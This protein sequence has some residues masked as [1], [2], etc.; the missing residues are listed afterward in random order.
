MRRDDP[1]IGDNPDTAYTTDVRSIK[2]GV[3]SEAEAKAIAQE[4]FT[5]DREA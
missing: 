1:K 2:T 4:D 5:Q 3:Q